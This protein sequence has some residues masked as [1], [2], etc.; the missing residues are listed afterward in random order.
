MTN[1]SGI[2]D[3]RRKFFR[4]PSSR[5]VLIID[6][7]PHLADDWSP[8]GF[9]VQMEAHGH[10]AGDII[11]G[12]IDVFERGEKGT[13]SAKVI[14]AEGD[15]IAAQFTELSS[16]IYIYICMINGQPIGTPPGAPK[17]HEDS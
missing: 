5:V 1:S 2:A 9:S 16:H 14:R 15:L 7:I 6:G 12:E 13:F 10:A 17:E 3:D 11:N 8:D 4:D